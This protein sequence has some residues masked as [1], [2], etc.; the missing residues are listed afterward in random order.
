MTRAVD[1]VAIGLS[2]LGSAPCNLSG[3]AVIEFNGFAGRARRQPMNSCAEMVRDKLLGYYR[4]GH[5]ILGLFGGV[6]VALMLAA[7]RPL[8]LL[9]KI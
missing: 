6:N 5:N 3:Q 7:G 4:G 8:Q 2:G 9:S 1:A